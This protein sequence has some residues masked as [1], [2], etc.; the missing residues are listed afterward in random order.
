MD[1]LW[2]RIYDLV[3]KTVISGE[4][5]VINALKKLNMGRGNC[6]QLLGFD[7]LVDSDLKPWVLE[8]NLSPSLATDS[9]LDHTIKATLLSDALNL[10]GIKR[11]NRRVEQI[12]KMR[13][14]YG[15]ISIASKGVPK[16]NSPGVLRRISIDLNSQ[17]RGSSHAGQQSPAKEELIDYTVT[18]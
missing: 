16:G 11:I 12:S 18:E 17:L 3:I 2:S 5:Y 15:H 4:H 8:V 1:L 10:V 9:P 6:F 14:R 7:V 13:T